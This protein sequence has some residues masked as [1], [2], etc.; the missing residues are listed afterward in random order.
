[1]LYYID[2]IGSWHARRN[3][4]F[5]GHCIDKT[6]HN[7]I[8]VTFLLHTDIPGVRICNAVYVIRQT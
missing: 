3:E 7:M 4:C 1:M 5:L 8:Y 6:A 2:S